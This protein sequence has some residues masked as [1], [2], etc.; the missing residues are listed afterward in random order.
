[1]FLSADG[2]VFA[3][4]ADQAGE[5]ESSLMAPETRG[6][7]QGFTDR[8]LPVC[9]RCRGALAFGAE[10]TGEAVDLGFYGEQCFDGLVDLLRLHG[11]DVS[12]GHGRAL[13]HP[14]LR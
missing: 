9:Q 6:G 13:S 4:V 3:E 12:P 11:E 10:F 1:R 5:T 2:E 8:A 7:L 14:E